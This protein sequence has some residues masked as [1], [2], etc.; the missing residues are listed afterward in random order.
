MGLA[1]PA[2][3]CVE[4]ADRRAAKD[5]IVNA[6]GTNA[7]GKRN[8]EHVWGDGNARFTDVSAA[9]G[10]WEVKV[11][12]SLWKDIIGKG[13]LVRR[14]EV[15]VLPTLG[16]SPNIIGLDA[17]SRTFDLVNN[18]FDDAYYTDIINVKTVGQ[19]GGTAAKGCNTCHDQLA[20]TFHSGDR[21]GNIRV[22]RV[23]H[24][25]SSAASHYELQSRSIDSYVHG[26]HTFEYPD[27]KSVNFADAFDAMEYK[28]HTESNFPR[29]GLAYG[30]TGGATDCESC[31]VAGKY[32][33][34]DQSKS[35][36]AL[37]SASATLTGKTNP[38]GTYPAYVSGPG[39]N[40]CGGC[41]RAQKI[42]EEDAG[43]LMSAW[44]HWQQN[45]Y[46]ITN[47][48]TLWNAVVA[49]VMAP[50]K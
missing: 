20:T 22:C 9:N 4:V 24:E 5:F 27:A 49:K 50:F 10:A 14:A 6:H 1:V 12:L 41:H 33:V 15:V 3:F 44:N 21:G 26:I 36:P 28:H 18:K 30:G 11:D 2:G 40:A 37:I 25:K 42:V 35:L 47:V 34:P 17:P 8:L 7:D 43:G 48:T 32:G 39:T 29:F 16:K 46:L 13:N 45:G 23:C 31:H 19:G 38:I